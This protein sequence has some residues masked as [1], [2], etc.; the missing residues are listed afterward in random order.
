MAAQHPMSAA[1]MRQRGAAPPDTGGARAGAGRH[2]GPGAGALALFPTPARAA[3]SHDDV[4]LDR[5]GGGRSEQSRAAKLVHNMKMFATEVKANLGAPDQPARAK[6]L[7]TLEAAQRS[8]ASTFDSGTNASRNGRKAAPVQSSF[9]LQMK[10]K[11]QA[12]ERAKVTRELK[13]ARGVQ[14][15]TK[16]APRLSNI[17]KTWLIR[18]GLGDPG[19]PARTLAKFACEFADDGTERDIR[20]PLSE[21]TVRNVRAAFADEVMDHSLEMIPRLYATVPLSGLSGG[22]STVVCLIHI[23]DELLMRVRTYDRAVD[24]CIVEGVPKSRIVRGRSSM[25]Q[26]NVLKLQ[27]G[28]EKLRILSDLQALASKDAEVIG[29]AL[30][31]AVEPILY[32]LAIASNKHGAKKVR[33]VH[34]ITGDGISTNAAAMNRVLYH[35]TRRPQRDLPANATESEKRLN[36]ILT[37]IIYAQVGIICGSHAGN[38]VVGAGVLDQ[39]RVLREQAGRRGAVKAEHDSLCANCVRWFKYLALAYDEEFSRSLRVD[40]AK[41]LNLH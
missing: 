39:T 34:V 10:V 17:S 30:I 26:Q 16:D 36:L 32:K 9:Q 31:D 18:I 24:E 13:R 15:A 11:Y 35:Y 22:Q 12:Q 19:V 25:V 6:C 23:Q 29:K 7:K 8:V 3:S 5:H 28:D 4:K 20:G 27:F 38:L 21:T 37:R 2:P 14:E 41:R 33:L 1:A 40:V